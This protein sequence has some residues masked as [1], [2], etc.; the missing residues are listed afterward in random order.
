MLAWLLTFGCPAPPAATGGGDSDVVDTEAAPTHTGDPVLPTVS[1]PTPETTAT[2][3]EP[4]GC[5]ILELGHDHDGDGYDAVVYSPPGCS[6]PPTYE[7]TGDCNDDATAIH[8]GASE[9]CD[10][11]DEDCDTLVDEDG[12]CDPWPG[13][14]ALSDAPAR[15]LL[16]TR[17]AQT[18]TVP[19]DETRGADENAASPG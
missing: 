8:P 11:I 19:G 13:T 7:P 5:T 4:L 2:A 18:S 3:T 10:G 16:G 12:A 1:I 6:L 15:Q 17:R 9:I 14:G